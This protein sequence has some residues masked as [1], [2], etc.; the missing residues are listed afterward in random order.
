MVKINSGGSA[1][2][3]KKAKPKG[4]SQPTE[5]DDAKPGEKFKAPAAP[6][7]WEPIS[8]DFPT[9]TAQKITLEEAAKNGTSFCAEC[10]AQA[11]NV[12]TPAV[13]EAVPTT[14]SG[15]SNFLQNGL[16]NAKQRRENP[17]P[18]DKGYKP[19]TDE[20]L[21]I[22]SKEDYFDPSPNDSVKFGIGLQNKILD[23]DILFYGDKDNNL[24]IGHREASIS[25]GYSYDPE[26][27]E[28][29]ISLIK[30]EGKISAVEGNLKGN[31]LNGLVEATAHGEVLSAK[32]TF[33]PLSVIHSATKTE[34]KS[35]VGVE[36]NL[37]KG[38]I[39]GQIN[40]TPK[41]IYDNTIGSV[42]GFF[43]PKSKYAKAP[44]WA[45]HGIVIGGKAEAGIGAAAKAHASAKV[46]N[47][48]ASAEIG[49]KAGFGPMAGFKLLLGIK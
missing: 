38:E 30:F 29:E 34:I 13:S 27:G 17:D 31:A 44:K 2:S 26:K 9:L 12:S 10:E 15:F 24:K 48:V 40:I 37:V 39:G 3:V 41:T 20:L 19:K 7:T 5:A 49:L 21:S 45:D 36:A 18:N 16:N 46:E 14:A 43:S 28:H 11:A 22:E 8:L 32:G 1:A 47:G 42:V 33:T 6:E 25:H 4:P 23:D 35:E